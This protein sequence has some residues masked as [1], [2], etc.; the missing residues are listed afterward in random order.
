LNTMNTKDTEPPD[1]AK[2]ALACPQFCVRHADV[3]LISR[4]P[5]DWT[6]TD[7]IVPIVFIFYFPQVWKRIGCRG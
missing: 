2:L 7:S 6:D 3:Q 1:L 4:V 5:I